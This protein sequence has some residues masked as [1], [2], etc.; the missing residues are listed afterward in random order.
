MAIFEEEESSTVIFAAKEVVTALVNI[1]RDIELIT[2]LK[3]FEFY[4]ELELK[5]DMT[6]TDKGSKVT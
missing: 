2:P 1:A 4:S 6:S 5:N 3:C